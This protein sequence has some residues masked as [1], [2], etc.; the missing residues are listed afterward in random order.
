MHCDAQYFNVVRER[1]LIDQSVQSVSIQDL[2]SG[3]S[4]PEHQP[5]CLLLAVSGL[6]FEWF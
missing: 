6:S 4:A 3:G 2:V 5:H 1:L